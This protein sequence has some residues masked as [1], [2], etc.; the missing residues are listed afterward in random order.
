M[1]GRLA[2]HREVLCKHGVFVSPGTVPNGAPRDAI[3]LA[4]VG[5]PFG[6]TS[7]N[8]EWSWACMHA[9]ACICMRMHAY[10]YACICMQSICICMHM[11]MI[12]RG[13][14][15]RQA[16]EATLLFGAGCRQRGQLKGQEWA[17]MGLGVGMGIPPTT[18]LG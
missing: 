16:G 9:Y 6:L 17:L 13:Q 15:E 10:A 5:L 12:A 14:P 1:P 8:F 11:Q 2:V 18:P 7:N 3:L 4:V